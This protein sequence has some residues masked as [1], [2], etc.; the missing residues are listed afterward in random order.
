MNVQSNKDFFENVDITKVKVY[1]KF[2]KKVEFENFRHIPSLKVEFR[3]P[4][5][6]ISGTN[7][8]GKTTLLMTIACS[9]FHFLRRNPTNGKLERNTWGALMKFTSE[10]KQKENWT[11][12][13]TYKQ[14]SK[15]NRKRG[16]RK[17]KTSKWNGIGKKE[18]Q[19][20][21]R[22]VV[23]IDIDRALPA[24]F[25]RRKIYNQARKGDLQDIS[26]NNVDRIENYLSY[27]FEEKLLV[28]TLAKVNNKDI[29]KY[30]NENEYSSFNTA[31]GED[32]LT[33]MIIDIVES[34]KESLIL[35]DEIEMGLHPK[36]QRRLIDVIRD[37]SRRDSKQFIIT[38]HSPTV[39][40][41]AGL[42]SRIFIEK[43][44]DGQF[45]AIQNIS[46]NAALSKMDSK[47]FPLVDIYCEDELSKKI[48]QKGINKVE[49]K[50]NLN[51]FNELIN[52]IPIG[53]ANK[54]YNCFK[55][56]EITYNLKKVKMGYGCILDGDM[57]MI[58]N[59]KGNPSYPENENLHFLFSHESP[60]VFLTKAYLEK[61]PNNKIEYY[62]KN[63]N[64][65]YLFKAIMENSGLNNENEVFESCWNYFIN[66]EQGKIYFGKL[67]E[68][69]LELA[70]KYSPD[71]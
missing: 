36:V 47:V 1:P 53:S 34:K 64:P 2:L 37:I 40:D 31:T 9:H 19:F 18:S 49:S 21:F 22:D 26:E 42:N 6:V 46:V 68:F 44:H 16:Q 59:G 43:N 4:I 25:F 52:I 63:E 17:A 55:A 15:I 5:S 28:K 24:R 8:S 30:Q 45:K 50:N 32:V 38:S 48:I 3:N 65:H 71:L 51:N 56:H 33:R 54:T 14:G 60:E 70:L 39:L 7:R 12:F 23:F 20:K 41:S 10:D 27:L 13:I 57:R 29:F 61:K 67:T 69:I 35:I 58:K 62:Y 66:S 11:Y